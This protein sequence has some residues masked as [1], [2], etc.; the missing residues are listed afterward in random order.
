[1]RKSIL[2]TEKENN[3]ELKSELESLKLELDSFKSKYESL[4]LMK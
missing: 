2:N 1:V 4:L 3:E